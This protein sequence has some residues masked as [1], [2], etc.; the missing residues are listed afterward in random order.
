MQSSH[1][2]FAKLRRDPSWLKMAFFSGN[3]LVPLDPSSVENC[4]EGSA[5]NKE[6]DFGSCDG[7]SA[8]SGQVS[9]VRRGFNLIPD[10]EYFF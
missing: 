2:I 8:L 4:R 10:R 9:S 1:G 6:E 5:A 3:Y 7:V